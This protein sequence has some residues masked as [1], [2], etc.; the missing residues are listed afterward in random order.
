[1][2]LTTKQFAELVDAQ[3]LC[4]TKWGQIGMARIL[5]DNTKEVGTLILPEIHEKITENNTVAHGFKVIASGQTWKEV[6]TKAGI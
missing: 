4:Y 3:A 2:K 1:M 5:N 6:L